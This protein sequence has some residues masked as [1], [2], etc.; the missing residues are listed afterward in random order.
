M[1]K[2][3]IRGYLDDQGRVIQMPSKRKKKILVLV[4]LADQIPDD[5]EYTE[6]EFNELLNELH[7]FGDAATLRRELFDHYLID[8]S[9]LGDHYSVKKDRPTPLELIER[10]C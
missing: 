8:R 7:T 2:K 3:E 10:Y 5:R 6:R 9:P 1:D 4:Y